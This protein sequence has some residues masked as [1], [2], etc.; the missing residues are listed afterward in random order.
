M[1]SLERLKQIIPEAA[2]GSQDALLEIYLGYAGDMIRARTRREQVP[3]GLI[4][5]REQVAAIYFRRQGM[6][7]ERSR[8]DGASSVTADDLPKSLIDQIDRWRSVVKGRY[9]CHPGA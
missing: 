6:E 2:D 3:D 5:V 4:G 1:T 7:G 9:A 8:S